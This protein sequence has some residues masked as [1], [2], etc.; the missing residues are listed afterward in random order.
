MAG[1][2]VVVFRSGDIT[3]TFFVEINA[4][5]SFNDF[6]EHEKHHPITKE[7]LKEV[8][9]IILKKAGKPKKEEK[10]QE[11]PAADK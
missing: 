1:Q 5:K 7:Q 4:K 3:I 11:Q 2:Q 10:K 8:H 6:Y 9:D